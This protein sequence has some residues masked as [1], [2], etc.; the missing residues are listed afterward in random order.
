M[1]K[2]IKRPIEVEAIKYTD[3]DNRFDVQEFVDGSSITATG[4]NG[5]LYL[6]YPGEA[7]APGYINGSIIVR[8]GDYVIKD[9][10]IGY[11]TCS[12]EDFEKNMILIEEDEE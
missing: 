12:G 3:W 6:T 7:G 10:A 1:A 9:D 11:Y 4:A 5:D 8:V 2:Y